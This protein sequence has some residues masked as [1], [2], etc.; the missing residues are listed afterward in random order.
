M[1]IMFN[2]ELD[3]KAQRDKEIG[4]FFL[5]I[6]HKKRPGAIRRRVRPAMVED[7]SGGRR[8]SI[9]LRIG[10]VAPFKYTHATKLLVT[11]AK[12]LLD[13]EVPSFAEVAEQIGLQR[14]PRFAVVA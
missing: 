11:Q 7:L 6:G 5:A 4:R 10:E 9:A 13:R 3:P 2:Y 1:I 8:G 14:V 12:Q